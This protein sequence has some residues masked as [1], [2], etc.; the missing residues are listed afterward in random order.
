MYSIDG[1]KEESEQEYENEKSKLSEIKVIEY[2]NS[3]YKN[4]RIIIVLK[5]C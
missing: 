5:F 2:Y 4:I 1:N 3:P